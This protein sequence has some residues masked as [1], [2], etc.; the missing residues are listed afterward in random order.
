MVFV[1]WD[2]M[3]EALVCLVAMLA[4][5]A[6]LRYSRRKRLAIQIP[7][8]ALSIP[9]AGLAMLLGLLLVLETFSGCRTNEQAV[10]SADGRRAARVE[11]FDA[12]ATGG[13]TWVRVYSNHGLQSGQAFVGEWDSVGR[14]GL[15]WD[16]N[17][18]LTVEYTGKLESCKDVVGI[19]V[20]CVRLLQ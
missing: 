12:G 7:L 1:D 17:M 2:L 9:I 10:Y 6:G 15:H 11:S 5:I 4:C 14:N 3:E 8:V 19:T 16:T 18:E 20:H 13:G